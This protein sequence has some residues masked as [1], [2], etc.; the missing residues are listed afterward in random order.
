MD[1]F[2]EK[3]MLALMKSIASELKGIRAELA[4][5]NEII[6]ELAEAQYVEEDEDDEGDT[7]FTNPDDED[8]ED[9]GDSDED[10]VE[11]GS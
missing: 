5:M 6:Y 9:E 1:P 2:T 11:I 8:D 10:Y 3:Q 4:D 7:P